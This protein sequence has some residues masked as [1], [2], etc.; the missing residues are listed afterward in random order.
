MDNV[1]LII[2]VIL[3]SVILLVLIG[4]VIYLLRKKSNL[5]VGGGYDYSEDIKEIRDSLAKSS[6]ETKSTIQDSLQNVS[7]TINTQINEQNKNLSDFKTDLLERNSKNNQ[8]ILNKVDSKFGDLTSKVESKM[9]ES[10]DKI[11]K[12]LKDGFNT[13]VQHLNLVNESLGK[14]TESQKSLDNLNQEVIKFNSVFSNSQV[15][16][17]FGEM[18]LERILQ[19]IFGEVRNMYELQYE[20]KTSKGSVRPDA[21]VFMDDNKT[22]LCIDSKFSFSEYEKVFDEN[23]REIEQKEL[24]ALKSALQGEIKKISKDYIIK[25]VTYIYALMFI[26]SDSIYNFIQ[27]NN[28]LYNNVIDYARRNNVLIVSP[29]TIQPILANINYLRL[30]VELSKNIKKVI[31][32]I[33]TV[34]KASETLNEKWNDFTK[35]F[36]SLKKKKENLDNPIENIYEKSKN[37]ISVALKNEVISEDELAVKNNETGDDV[38]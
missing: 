9:N 24:T 22:I 3:M 2:I 30:N 18:R 23:P 15:R 20:I 17:R 38:S 33:N 6:L 13:N 10:N 32:E 31:E 5:V 36:E 29:S 34:R 19:E 8:E 1:V 35:T 26:P 25:N 21:V 7:K 37:A 12:N 11:D 16:G 27:L 14:I 28:Y 4:L